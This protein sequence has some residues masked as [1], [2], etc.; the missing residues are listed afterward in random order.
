MDE[1]VLPRDEHVPEHDQA[2]GFV[3]T[4]RQRIVERA[5]P[6]GCIRTARVEP[7][8]LGGDRHDD[9]DRVV[10]VAGL[11]RDDRAQEQVIGD[12]RGRPDHLGA[13][14]DDAVVALRYDARVEKLLGLVVGGL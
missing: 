6:H 9:G 2:V 4:R 14:D 7:E 3:E 1:D 11:E 8:P 5:R 12:R 13:P 10:L